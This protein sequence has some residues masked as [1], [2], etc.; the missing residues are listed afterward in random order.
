MVTEKKKRQ[1]EEEEEEAEA[2]QIMMQL[3]Q[4]WKEASEKAELELSSLM[5]SVKRSIKC[6]VLES[7]ASMK[8]M[9]YT[10][11]SVKKQ[12]TAKGNAANK[13]LVSTPK[14]K[15]S[16]KRK[17]TSTITPKW[18]QV[19]IPSTDS[20]S[21]TPVIL[22]TP[23]PPPN[24]RKRVSK[25]QQQQLQE[26]HKQDNVKSSC[27]TTKSGTGNCEAHHKEQGIIL[28]LSASEVEAAA[29]EA[30]TAEAEAAIAALIGSSVSSSSSSANP[31]ELSFVTPENYS[32]YF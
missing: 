12:D 8:V 20:S 7:I 11:S 30:A 23:P 29:A 31:Y 4:Q 2:G 6:V 5:L 16:R 22:P 18:A 13:P 19:V 24:K 25:K 32:G 3:R 27:E 9:S 1:K 10:M 26:Q 14:P 15:S 28:Q 21:S 17:A